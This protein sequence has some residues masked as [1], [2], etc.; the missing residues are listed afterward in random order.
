MITLELDFRKK[1]QWYLRIDTCDNMCSSDFFSRLEK[2]ANGGI[3]EMK[4]GKIMIKKW[5]QNLHTKGNVPNLRLN[6][7]FRE[8][9]LRFVYSRSIHFYFIL[10]FVGSNSLYRL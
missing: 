4:E 10:F 6:G 3:H 1:K 9:N 5:S 2:S 8:L 7:L